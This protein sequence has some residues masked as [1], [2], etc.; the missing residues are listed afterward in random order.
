MDYIRGCR[1][2]RVITQNP[3]EIQHKR[4][5]SQAEVIQKNIN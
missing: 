3:Q 5:K 2:V 4:S 1:P